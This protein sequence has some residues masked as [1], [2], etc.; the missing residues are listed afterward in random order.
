[1]VTY[2]HERFIEQAIESALMQVTNFDYEIVIGEDCSTDRTREIVVDYQ[3]RHPEK[4]RLLLQQQ[5]TGGARNFSQAFQACT[6]EYVALL[7]G[8]DYWT[9]SHKLESQIQFLAAHPDYAI[10]FHPVEW[11]Y[12]DEVKPGCAI[13]ERSVW[14]DNP[15]ETSTLEDIL[16]SVY[17]QSSSVVFRNH[18][19]ENYPEWIYE[20]PFG[21]WPLFVLHADHGKI[22]CLSEVMSAYRRHTGG[23]WFAVEDEAR[24]LAVIKMYG[25][26]NTHFNYK[27][28][29]MIRPLL[30]EYYQRLGE[31]YDSAGNQEMALAPIARSIAARLWS[32]TL[33]PLNSFKML[34][35]LSLPSLYAFSKRFRRSA[36][37]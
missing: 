10:C 15:P 37:L 31:F 35:R 4:I 18:L 27:Y 14:P 9:C 20:L 7:D 22:G 32:G 11:F 19:F 28:A 1:M 23:V 29:G 12:Q 34:A 2:N 17:I 24:Y 36:A 30:A 16:R 21:D 13:P 8:D 33:P 26:L 6:G 3:K 5:N 25:F